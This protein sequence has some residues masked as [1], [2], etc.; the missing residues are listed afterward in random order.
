MSCACKKQRILSI[1]PRKVINDA[2]LLL[3]LLLLVMVLVLGIMHCCCSEVWYA[4]VIDTRHVLFQGR[5]PTAQL[6]LLLVVVLLLQD[7]HAFILLPT[8][9][10]T[11]PR[12]GPTPPLTPLTPTA[13]SSSSSSRSGGGL[14][15][16]RMHML[17]H[18]HCAPPFSPLT[19]SPHSPGLKCIPSFRHGLQPLLLPAA[20]ATAGDAAAA[21][22]VAAVALHPTCTCWNFYCCCCCVWNVF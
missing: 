11:Q 21:A 20:V 10:I 13:A 12:V 8:I 4:A 3:L 1:I 6:L 2:I 18:A 7:T 16:M 22:A 15:G 14:A 17:A 9:G 5:G 19:L